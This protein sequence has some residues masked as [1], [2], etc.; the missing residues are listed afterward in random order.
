MK[1][2]SILCLILVLNGCMGFGGITTEPA[3]IETEY[4]SISDEKNEF[5]DDRNPTRLTKEILI[6]TWGDPDEISEEGQ[7]EVVTYYDGK[8]WTGTYIQLLIFPL[9]LYSPSEYFNENRFYFVNGESVALVKK[10][11]LPAKCS[12]VIIGVLANAVTDCS[13]VTREAENIKAGNAGKLTGIKV[14]R[15]DENFAMD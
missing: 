14:K 13:K 15:C 7:C 12:G 9:P 8:I 6:S 1:I 5:D 11:G 3:E 4:F 10:E 2:L